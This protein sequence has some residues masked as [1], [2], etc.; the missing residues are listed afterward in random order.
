M[1]AIARDHLA[2][3][4]GC[5]VSVAGF[6]EWEAG[7]A[8]ADLVAAAQSWHWLEH[9]LALPKVA[10]LL[11]RPG[12]LAVFA[13]TPRPQDTDL[14]AELDAVYRALAPS[15]ADTSV[16]RLWS[17][18]PAAAEQWPAAMMAHG[19]DRPGVHHYDW[20]RAY[21]TEEYVALLR[22]HSD[23]RLRPPD[24]LGAL[25]NGVARVLDANGGQVNFAYRAVL[26][27]ARP[28]D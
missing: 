15:L 19:F 23:H 7:A 20:A 9:G 25:L 24:H 11:R 22:T 2:A 10:R 27:L 14:G 3:F 13:N 21:S 26:L 16:M 12:A 6:E 17:N 5:S 1:A 28:D 4:P 8:T 18:G